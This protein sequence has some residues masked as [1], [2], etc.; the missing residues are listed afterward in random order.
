MLLAA[1]ATLL[2]MAV[3]VFAGAQTRTLA[4]YSGSADGLAAESSTALRSEL[5]RLVTPAGISVIWKD[6]SH[7][8]SGEDFDIVVVGSFQGS[9]SVNDLPSSRSDGLENEMS[10]AETSTS[11]GRILPFLNVDCGRLV[12]MLT[13]QLE[14]LALPSRQI[15][16]GRALGRVIAHEIYHIVGQTAEHH[17]TGV[18]KATLSVRD[19]TTLR[20]DFDPWSLARLRPPSMEASSVTEG[21]DVS[22][23]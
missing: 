2:I 9:C 10:L 1:R 4:V 21:G 11:N 19:L 17:D 15:M 23:R 16:L 5:Q 6:L 18:T 14:S 7:R 13:P 20:F 3:S 12:R 22:G 8:K